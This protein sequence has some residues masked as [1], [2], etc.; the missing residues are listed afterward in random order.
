[1]P[2]IAGF[3]LASGSHV[4]IVKLPVTVLGISLIVGSGCVYNNY[5]DRNIDKKMERTK[6]RA[7]ALGLISTRGTLIYA[8]CLGL[9][10][11]GL[12]LC[13][14]NTT[15]ALIGV[16]GLVDYVILYG[17]SK[18]KSV[19]GTLVGSI[20]GAT[21]PLAGFTAVSGHLNTGGLLLFLIL[22][23]WQMPHFYAIA[24]Y[25]AKDYAAAK[26]PVLPVRRGMSTAKLH[27]TVYIF[28]FICATI[29]LFLDGFVGVP[30]MIIMLVVGL[31]WLWSAAMGFRK[32]VDNSK[33]ARGIF[34]QSLLVITIFCV[35]V[36]ASAILSGGVH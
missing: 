29:L 1:L 15:T 21:P 6:A 17:Y 30:Y 22:I 19:Y 14:T 32:G 7:T 16:V 26:I 24:M 31:W 12:L 8:T 34:F 33:W 18:R 20:S 23:F 13:F 3:L 28:W 9:V 10:G 36:S 25:R 27:I 35:T 5:L 4:N 11:F 2:A